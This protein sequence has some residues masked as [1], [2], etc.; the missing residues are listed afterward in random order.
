MKRLTFAGYAFATA[1]VLSGC[2]VGPR[3]Q[4]PAV[5]APPAYRDAPSVTTDASASTASVGDLKWSEVF[6][7]EQLKELIDEALTKNFDVRIAAQRVLEQQAQVGITRSQALPSLSAGG[8]YS[9]I[10]IPTDA[11]GSNY[12]STF[13]GGGMIADAAWNL[14][15][16]GLYRRQNEA[17]RAKLLATEWGRRA[18]LSSVVMNV[19]ASYI[20]LRTLDAKLEITR[21]TLDSRRESLRLVTLREQVGSATMSDVHQSEQL[22][23]AAEAAQPDIE[24]DIREQENSISLLLGRNPGP[25]PRSK[26]SIEQPD[27]QEV[28]PGIP[29]Q[30]LERRPDIQKAEA[31]LIAANARIGVARAQFFPQIS[32][33]GMGGTATSQ[34]NKLFNSD[35]SFWFGSVSVSQPLFEGGKLRNNLRL[36][37]ETKQEMVL[38]Y[39]QTIASAFRDVS[40]ALITYQKSKENRIAQEKETAAADKSVQLAHIRYDNGGSSYLEVLTNDTNLFSAELNLADAQQQEALSLVQLYGALGGGWR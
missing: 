27:P 13:H 4:R 18:T 15:F 36:A 12:P 32:I 39:Q 35:A 10:G 2:M 31:Q 1:T 38:A 19:A 21:K 29:S 33:T 24:R 14:D 7:D 20:Q 22:L 17:E 23:Y 3:Y 25:I 28:P 30:L 40:N 26:G 6:K 34:L 37:E 9:A 11:L 5:V 8:S 16:W